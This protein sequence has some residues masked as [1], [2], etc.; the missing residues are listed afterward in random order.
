MKTKEKEW[1]NTWK[2]RKIY[3]QTNKNKGSGIYYTMKTMGYVKST[4][5]KKKEEV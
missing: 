4:R 3:K 1:T 2:Q 5:W